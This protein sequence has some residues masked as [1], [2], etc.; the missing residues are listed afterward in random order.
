MSARQYSSSNSS[1][2][3]FTAQS[4]IS[5]I[6][7]FFV[8]HNKKALNRGAAKQEILLKLP[9]TVHICV[10]VGDLREELHSGKKKR[11]V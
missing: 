8:R 10:S 1:S 6:F 9:F 3:L 5:W 11:I 7:F 4:E 2:S